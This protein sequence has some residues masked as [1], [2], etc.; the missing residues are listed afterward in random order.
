M[1]N[2]SAF[3]TP[4][5]A[6]AVNVA[7]PEIQRHFRVDVIVL[8]WVHTSYLLATSI[9]LL[10][11]GKLADMLGRRKIFVYGISLFT[12]AS[13]LSAL[14]PNIWML[15]ASRVVQGLGSAMIFGTGMAMIA[16]AFPPGERGK[17]I[18]LNVTVVYLG[19]SV[20]PFVGGILTQYFSWRGVFFATIPVGILTTCISIWRLKWS[21]HRPPFEGFDVI[22]SLIYGVSIMFFMVGL[23]GIPSNRG[24]LGVAL[25]LVL[26]I[27]FVAWE[28]K[29]ASPV[30]NVDL[31]RANRPFALSSAAALI[32]YS[33]TFAV[34]FLLSLYLQYMR[35]LNPLQTGLVLMALPITMALFSPFAGRLSD[36]IQPRKVASVGMALTAFGLFSMAFASEH[37]SITTVVLNL[38]LVGLGFALFSSPNMN[39]IMTSVNPADYGLASSTVGTMRLLGQMLSM[40]IA[41][42]MFSLYLGS[43]S[44]TPQM[45]PLFLKCVTATFCVFGF[46]CVL[47]I[48]ASLARG[49]IDT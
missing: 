37:P 45:Y 15:L 3:L 48:L 17:A 24:F 35:N 1:A 44:M 6:A 9:F 32:N 19:Q 34:T 41:S 21:W 13:C 25:G 33:A 11:A 2:L 38:M 10:P 16:T 27:I 47:G 20:A 39:A 4:F 28:L 26:F 40:G 14:S 49:K 29:V 46:T 43:Q 42:L 12:L 23:S 30:L 22:G 36:R 31:F 8:S 18:G 5:M 7:L